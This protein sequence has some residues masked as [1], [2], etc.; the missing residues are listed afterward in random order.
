MTLM[1]QAQFLAFLVSE[2]RRYP[3]FNIV[4]GANVRELVEADCI[5]RGIRYQAHDG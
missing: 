2:A 3:A 5:V 4:M 1:A